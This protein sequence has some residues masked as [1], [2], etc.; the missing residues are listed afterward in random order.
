MCCHQLVAE[1]IEHVLKTWPHVSFAFADFVLYPFVVANHGAEYHYM[2]SPVSL[3]GKSGNLGMVLQ[4]P[5]TPCHHAAF[6]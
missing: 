5:E 2:L 1:K 3:S 4:M 6:C